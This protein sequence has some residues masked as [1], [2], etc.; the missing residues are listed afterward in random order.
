MPCLFIGTAAIFPRI[1][2]VLMWL[3]QYTATA[4]TT[5][6]W[7]ILGFFFLPY[8]TCAYAIGMKETG[9]FQGWTLIL[10]II[11]IL[12]DFGTLGGSGSR[13]RKLR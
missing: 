4:F 1:A 10:L 7:P 2:L 11:G 9:G 5:Q 6:L 8:T 12:L 3:I 13:Y